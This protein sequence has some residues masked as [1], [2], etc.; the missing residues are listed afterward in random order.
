MAYLIPENMFENITINTGTAIVT[1]EV[2]VEMFDEDDGYIT[3]TIPK[4][5]Y[6]Y[7]ELNFRGW[8]PTQLLL[9][10]GYIDVAGASNLEAIIYI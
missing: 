2:T 9:E 1:E 6:K 4:G 3:V 5:E 10:G 7:R 8:K